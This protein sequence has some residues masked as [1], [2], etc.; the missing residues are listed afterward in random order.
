VRGDKEAVFSSSED[1]IRDGGTAAI[2]GPSVVQREARAGLAAVRM[3]GAT[4]SFFTLLFPSDCRVCGLALRNISQLS[5]RP[6]CVKVVKPAVNKL[7]SMCRQTVSSSCSCGLS[8]DDRIHRFPFC[9]RSERTFER[10][11]A[12]GS[13]HGGRGAFSVARA[14]E[15]TGCEVGLVD[16]VYTTGTT[17]SECAGVPARAGASKVWVATVAR[18]LKLASKYQETNTVATTLEA[19]FDVSGSRAF[20]DE[21]GRT[22]KG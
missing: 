12:Y 22:L 9:R 17:V 3:R 4:E 1:R 10:A 5:G 11:V 21:A 8:D 13:H 19:G 6:A 15:V 18:T 7:G 2:L 16:D 14:R 20:R